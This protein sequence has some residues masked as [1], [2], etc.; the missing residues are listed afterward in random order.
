MKLI[1]RYIIS[2]VIG[3]VLLVL[4]VIV[5]LSSFMLF[6]GQFDDIGVGRY[7][8]GDA[9]MYVILKAPQQAYEI[10]PI[11]ALMGSLLGLG[12]LATHSELIVMRAAGVTTW[13]LAGSVAMAG[14]LM[15]MF[16]AGLGEVLAPPAEQY[17]VS[18]KAISMHSRL[19]FTSNGTWLRNGDTFIS[20]GNLESQSDLGQ[21]TI[22]SF[23][24]EGGLEVAATAG[25][26]LYQDGDWQVYG[27]SESQLHA[28]GT[29]AVSET[30]SRN[31]SQGMD[32][33][34]M[35]LVAQDPDALGMVGLMDYVAYLQRNSLDDANFKLA[36]YSRVSTL[37]AV[38]FMVVLALPFNFGA[39]RSAG[40]GQRVFFGV[41]IG[42]GF[43]LFD[44]TF[45]NTGA[46]YGLAPMLTAWLPTLVLMALTLGLIKRV[47]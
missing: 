42:A 45:G 44:R 26:A 33:D 13:R 46:V 5:A 6:V 1:D 11:A 30:Q 9:F 31:W 43:F 16:A 34:L 24:R 40:T 18:S 41:L 29:V 32:P 21:V 37:V 22:Y 27:Y 4:T 3:G 19:A 38:L 25:R 36:L 14:V 23:D 28:D 47:Q 20:V 10:F 12:N 15:A 17:A 8:L 39:L 2:S 7:A 35:N